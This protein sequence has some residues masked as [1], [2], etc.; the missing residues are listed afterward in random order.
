MLRGTTRFDI[1]IED[2]RAVSLHLTFNEKSRRAVVA[3]DN[4]M[5]GAARVYQI[6]REDQ[7]KP[8]KMKVFPNMAEA[9]RWLG[10]DE[11]T[12]SN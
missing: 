5:Y 7:K 1:S 10:L 11:A 3:E 4:E 8:D 9:R 12:N 6:L 2:M